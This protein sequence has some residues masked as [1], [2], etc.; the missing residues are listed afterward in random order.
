VLREH[1][2]IALHELGD[3]L[4]VLAHDPEHQIVGAPVH[5]VGALLVIV[6]ALEVGGEHRLLALVLDP[7]ERVHHV[8]LREC[9][10]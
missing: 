9:E 8:R 10:R 7:A 1:V 6:G 3:L 4:V 2:W 5:V